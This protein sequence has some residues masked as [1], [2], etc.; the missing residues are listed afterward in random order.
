MTSFRKALVIGATGLI[1]QALIKQLNESGAYQEIH[2]F[3]RKPLEISYPHVNSHI[4]DFDS[5]EK[6]NYPHVDDV[7]CCLGTTMKK[8]KSKDAFKKVDYYYP[9]M[10]ARGAL[11]KGAKQFLVVS[12]IGA[13]VN[14][15]FFYSRVKGELERDLIE[16]GYPH[17]HIF[18]PS[19]LLGERKE[20][21][22]GEKLGEYGVK[23]L[24]PLLRGRWSNYQAIEGE[25]VA[26]AMVQAALTEDEEKVK[27]YE[28]CQMNKWWNNVN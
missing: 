17:I 14:S 5:L 26:A 24:G 13:N 3:V 1:G 23:L 22:I 7:F 25:A 19:L 10:I 15:T 27:V 20:L 11:A 12:A 9:L 8:A 4:V 6:S 16:L 28:S 21:R 18:R 2:L